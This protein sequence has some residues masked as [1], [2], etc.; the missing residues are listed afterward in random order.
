MAWAA[1]C[2]WNPRFETA[3]VEDM[4]DVLQKCHSENPA[5]ISLFAVV[6]RGRCRI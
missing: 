1:F 2:H 3:I 5:G 4:L 6:D